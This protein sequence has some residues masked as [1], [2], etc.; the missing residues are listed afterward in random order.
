MS[1]PGRPTRNDEPSTISVKFRVTD[2]ERRKL[3]LAA[4]ANRQDLSNFLRD[5]SLDAASETLEDDAPNE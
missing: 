5:V 3:R 4:A 2:E 1:Q